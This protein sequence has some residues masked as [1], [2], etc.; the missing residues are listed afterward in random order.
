MIQIWRKAS[1]INANW[2]FNRLVF[3][4]KTTHKYSFK[5]YYVH[6]TFFPLNF[7]TLGR[8]SWLV[9]S[10]LRCLAFPMVSSNTTSSTPHGSVYQITSLLRLDRCRN[11]LSSTAQAHCK[12]QGHFHREQSSRSQSSLLTQV[13]F[14]AC[15]SSV[16]N[17]AV[18]WVYNPLL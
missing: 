4:K 7:N 13:G 12:L 5:Y 18:T 3:F 8:S 11:G 15:R 2:I 1:S 14:E 17:L 10:Q 16:W 6:S 9:P